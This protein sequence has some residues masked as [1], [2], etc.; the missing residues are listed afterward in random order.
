[1]STAQLRESAREAERL[2]LWNSAACLWDKAIAAYP[3]GG[4]GAL[5]KRDIAQMKERADSCRR[6][7]VAYIKSIGA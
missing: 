2:F 7:L 5:A 1:M 3:N 4:R 6:E